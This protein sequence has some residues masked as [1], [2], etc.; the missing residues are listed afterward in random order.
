MEGWKKL[1]HPDDRVRMEHYFRDEVIDQAQPFNEEY[2]ILR[3]DDHT[4]HWV[5]GLGMLEFDE[6]N[7]PM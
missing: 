1:L 2:C 7:N 4:K 5:H 6:Y 3:H